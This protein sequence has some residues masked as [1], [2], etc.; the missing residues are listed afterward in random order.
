MDSSTNCQLCP[1]FVGYAHN[2]IVHACISHYNP[3]N[4]YVLQFHEKQFVLRSIE[5]HDSQCSRVE[6]DESG[7]ASKEYGINRSSIF[8]QLRYYHVCNGSLLPDIMHDILEGALQYEIKLLLHN[9]IEV[10]KFFSLDTFNSCLE[11]LE[12]GYMESKNKPSLI[13]TTTYKSSTNSLKQ[14]GM[15]ICKNN[16]HMHSLCNLAS[17]M[18]LL[19][20]ILP[21][22]IGDWVPEDDSHWLL[23]LSMMEI[24]DLVFS[25]RLSHDHVAYL[26]SLI[27]DHHHDF[28]RLYPDQHVIPK[29]HFM[30]HMPRLIIQ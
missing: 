24:V 6:E 2:Y 20:R 14:N 12:L 8:N 1:L 17:Q 26:S 13:S 22:T 19:G 27:N 7:E 18:W 16:V 5:S 4:S 28:R 10:K 15:D 30:V 25:P 21:L 23:Y 11:N 9:L 3:S 29:M